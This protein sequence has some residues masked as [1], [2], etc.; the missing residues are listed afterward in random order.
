MEQKFLVTD[1][2]NRSHLLH[3]GNGTDTS[4]TTVFGP[5]LCGQILVPSQKFLVHRTSDLGQSRTHLLLL[6]LIRLTLPRVV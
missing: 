3:P 5:I 6:M 1:A 2:R 4:K